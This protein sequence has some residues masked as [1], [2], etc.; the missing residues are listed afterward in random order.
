MM[1]Y[2]FIVLL[3]FSGIGAGY[4][5]PSLDSLERA[6]PSLTND[7]LRHR[8][9]TQ[10]A[11]GLQY[12]E[13]K[14]AEAFT[15]EALAL[16]E[17]N[18][19]SWALAETYKRIGFLSTISGDY[20]RAIKYDNLGLELA[21][22]RN[23]SVGIAE[24]LNF[25]GNDYS[26]L[27]QYDQAY[28]Y[29]TQSYRVGQLVNDRMR[30][31]IAL[32]NLGNVFRNLEQFEVAL[33]YLQ[34]SMRISQEI[35][36]LDGIPYSYESIGAVYAQKRDFAQAK[37]NF[38]QA[39]ATLRE[40][41]LTVIEPRVL[42]R[43]GDLYSEQ[44]QFAVALAYYDSAQ[45][46]Q[47]NTQNELGLAEI[48]FGKAKIFIAQNNFTEAT[49]LLTGSMTT[50]RSLK[51]MKLYID[52]L[53]TLSEAEEK[54][55][56]F[57]AA[58]NHLQRY[59]AMRDSIYN[60]GMMEKLFRE[61]VR[62]ATANKDEEIAE[63][64][65]IKTQRE[66]EL[67]EQKELVQQQSFVR[68]ILVV[69]VALTVILLFTVYRS[70]QRRK[71]INRLLL[72]HQEEIKKRSFELEQLNKVKDKF[73]SI[74]SHDLRSPINALYSIVDLIDRK[75][76]SGTELENIMKELKM[77]VNHTRTLINNLLDW[78]LLQ[79]DNLKIQ[80]Q[81]ID[82]K[83]VVDDTITL[84]ASMQTKEITIENRVPKGTLALGDLNMV[85]LVFRNL[86]MN[87]LKFTEAG[88]KITIDSQD[89]GHYYRIAIADNGVGIAP[90]V[91]KLLFEK[92]T[93]YTTRG[94]ANEKGTGLGLI[95]CREFIERNG[96]KI[97][98][99]SELGKGST[100]YFTLRKA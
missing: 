94:T 28:Y 52:C 91:Q 22:Q 81:R 84:L 67:S 58:L 73:F 5:Q 36:D 26:D 50:A 12:T 60:S 77:R 45:I 87:G 38:D 7:S 34:R 65:K 35:K 98:L 19:W 23:D 88:G 68:N 93:G 74:I 100:F 31:T 6:L 24:A 61:Q 9:L 59:Y 39:L 10:L 99:E 69:V 40:R 25:L 42:T 75:Q 57:P 2:T 78:A 37:F 46:L 90:E 32:H 82:L 76:M 92:T 72:E 48:A 79:M 86:I 53:K 33:N 43:L 95:L 49:Q 89:D 27:G 62:Y 66:K 97:W 63:L 85:N 71:R 18:N 41:K 20:S 55:K 1:R 51:A 56:N 70:G 14:K 64:N 21:T 96:G 29:F 8:V 83:P 4:A 44:K 47:E 30:M 80:L 17:K 54:K 13:Y 16:A 3:C 11:E 15:T